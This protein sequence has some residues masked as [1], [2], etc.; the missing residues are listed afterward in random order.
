MGV[1]Y[2]RTKGLTAYTDIWILQHRYG[3]L[4]NLGILRCCCLVY[5]LYLLKVWFSHDALSRMVAEKCNEQLVHMHCFIND[6]NPLHEVQKGDWFHRYRKI[7][8]KLL[9]PHIRVHCQVH[10]RLRV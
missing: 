6:S 9:A 8:L 1:E 2:E 7:Y 10:Q 5:L 4:Y 3:K